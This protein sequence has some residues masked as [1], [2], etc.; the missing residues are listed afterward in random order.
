MTAVQAKKYIINFFKNATFTDW[1]QLKE[2]CASCAIE[3]NIEAENALKI[4]KKISPFDTKSIRNMFIDESNRKEIISL[5]FLC[6]HF[7]IKNIK[8]KI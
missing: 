2:A 6:K 8:N 7:I 1:N 5:G 4:M 3:G